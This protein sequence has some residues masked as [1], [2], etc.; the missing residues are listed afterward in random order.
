MAAGALVFTVAL[1]GLPG[2]AATDPGESLPAAESSRAR[3]AHWEAAAGMF[4]DDPLTGQGIGSYRLASGR[5]AP[6]SANPSAHA[7]NEFVELAAEGGLL[8]AVPAALL[9]AGV[10]GAALR[11]VKRRH[12]ID[13]A[14]RVALGAAVVWLALGAHAVI[15][16]DWLFPV[17]GLAFAVAAGLI[18]PKAPGR[19]RRWPVYVVGAIFVVALGAVFVEGFRR[20]EGAVHPPWNA[21]AAAALAQRT[22]DDGDLERAIAIATS[23]QAWNPGDPRPAVWKALARIESD[24]P[25]PVVTAAQRAHPG[26]GI[27][28]DAAQ[29]L[30]DAGVA[31]EAGEL[32]DGVIAGF[33]DHAGWKLGGAAAVAYRLHI[34]VTGELAGCEAAREAARTAL[35]TRLAMSFGD[36]NYAAQ[37]EVYCR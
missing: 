26:F 34:Q 2:T 3:L 5:W 18:A 24:G 28:L 32:V 33:D 20:T 29:A 23:A 21:T 31:A 37:A 17:L 7:H 19:G 36:E 10:L 4:F 9:L 25:R 16:F 27:R 8:L 14:G 12:P 11:A 13:P 15:D 22:I 6:G 35:T 1:T 30:L